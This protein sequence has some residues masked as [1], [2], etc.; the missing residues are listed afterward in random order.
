MPRY[1][2]L[3]NLYSPLGKTEKSLHPFFPGCCA[4]K[5]N[6]IAAAIFRTTV[7]FLATH[8]SQHLFCPKSATTEEIDCTLKIRHHPPKICISK[9]L[10][11]LERTLVKMIFCS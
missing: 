3:V 5:P 10:D 6:K 7:F 2:S 1:S 9:I 11:V 4:K 8:T